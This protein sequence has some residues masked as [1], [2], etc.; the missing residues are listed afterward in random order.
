MITTDW[1]PNNGA[2]FLRHTFAI[3]DVHGR[4]TT[5]NQLLDHLE[6][7]PVYGRVREIIFAG[8]L[9]D[10]GPDSLGSIQRAWEALDRFDYGT[11]LPGNHELMMVSALDFDPF[12]L[13]N[14]L[15]NGGNTALKQVDPREALDIPERLRAFRAALPLGFEELMRTGPTHLVRNGCLFVHAG[16]HPHMDRNEFLAAPRFEVGD[17]HWA[18]IRQPFLSWE[19]GWEHLGLRLVVHGHS[20][21]ITRLFEDKEQ[22]E[23]YL[24]VVTEHAAIC[25]DAGAAAVPQVAA[26]EFAG[27]YHRLHVAQGSDGN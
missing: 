22:A 26:V 21:A 4:A 7:L 8:D 18:W 24:D 11:L 1:R 12:M 5:L 9:T 2:E 6:D 10:R 25:V 14:W 23:R 17:T 16:L 19:G 13:R 27:W 3:G 15:A 20:P